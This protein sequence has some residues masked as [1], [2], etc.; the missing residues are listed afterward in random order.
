MTFRGQQRDAGRMWHQGIT[1]RRLGYHEV[2]IARRKLQ[3][4]LTLDSGVHAQ[5]QSVLNVGASLIA[6]PLEDECGAARR[7][8]SP[9]HQIP[10]T[11]S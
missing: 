2:G 10:R 11:V 8:A 9:S 7:P 5:R 1:G 4:L 3:F 6:C